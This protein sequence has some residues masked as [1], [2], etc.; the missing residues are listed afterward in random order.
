MPFEQHRDT[1]A[2]SAGAMRTTWFEPSAVVLDSM[3]RGRLENPSSSTTAT[4][5]VRYGHCCAMAATPGSATSV[6]IQTGLELRR[7]GSTG[8]T[9]LSVKTRYVRLSGETPLLTSVLVAHSGIARAPAATPAL[10][11]GR[12]KQRA[13]DR[14]TR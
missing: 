10:Q 2:P 1:G 8:S 4:T 14:E 9:A 6:T 5:A 7:H 11:H 12:S 13:G 3:D